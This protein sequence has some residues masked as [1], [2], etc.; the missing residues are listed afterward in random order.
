[1]AATTPEKRYAIYFVPAEETA[2]YQFGASILGYDTYTGR[3]VAL[4]D[5]LDRAT[6]M[7]VVREPRKYGFHATLKA[8]FRLAMGLSEADLEQELVDFARDQSAVTIGPMAVVDLGS[9]IA[10]V[11]TSTPVALDRLAEACVRRFD[12]FRAALTAAERERRL[13]ASLTARQKDNMEQWG[14][15]FVCEDFRFHMS[16]TGRLLPPVQQKLLPWLRDDFVRIQNAMPVTVDR[17]VVARQIGDAPFQ[18][19]RRVDLA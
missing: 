3:D 1:M 16:L 5:G 17:L 8:P 11:P 9:F 6:W 10:L 14:Y 2:L 15:P 13:R 19:I 7:D 4:P 18:V 12:R